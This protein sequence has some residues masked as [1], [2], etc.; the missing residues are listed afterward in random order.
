MYGIMDTLEKVT[1][2]KRYQS[3]KFCYDIA[4]NGVIEYDKDKEIKWLKIGESEHFT[5]TRDLT[6]IMQMISKQDSWLKYFIDGS[7]H[8]YKV[9]DITYNNNVYPIIAGQVGIC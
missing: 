2:G 4:M 5:K 8:T 7:R 9:D 1:H 6:H 3:H